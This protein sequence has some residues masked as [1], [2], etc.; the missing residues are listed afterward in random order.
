MIVAYVAT[1]DHIIFPAKNNFEK[2][3]FLKKWFKIVPI[4]IWLA[5]N[6]NFM[7]SKTYFC[8]LSM[9]AIAAAVEVPDTILVSGTELLVGRTRYCTW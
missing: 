5:E 4:E 1:D 8:F 6:Q 2:E 7:N 9:Q 3:M